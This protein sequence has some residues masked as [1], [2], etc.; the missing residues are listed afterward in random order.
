[1]VNTVSKRGDVAPQH[2]HSGSET[3]R[4]SCRP[5]AELLL[6]AGKQEWCQ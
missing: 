4:P 1:M 2:C 3:Y 5:T 6:G